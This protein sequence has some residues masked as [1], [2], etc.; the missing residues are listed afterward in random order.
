[1]TN[2]KIGF[3]TKMILVNN[4]RGCKFHDSGSDIREDIFGCIADN[5]EKTNELT[6]ILDKLCSKVKI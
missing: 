5:P 2:G 4:I 3:R 6:S 1:M